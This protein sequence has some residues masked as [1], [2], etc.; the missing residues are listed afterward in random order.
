MNSNNKRNSVKKDYDLIAGQ[1]CEEFGEYI[2]DLDIYEEFEKYL[3]LGDT[4]LDLGAGAGRTYC[5]FNKK[6]YN[7]IALDFSSKMRECAFKKYGVFPYILD[8]MVNIKKHFS[9]NTIDAV[10]V[11][12]SLFHLPKDD[13]E[14]LMLDL[15]DILKNNGLILLSF[16]LGDGE[17]F[18][19]EPYLKSNG[20][21]VLYMNYMDKT[22]IFDLLK[23]NKFDILYTKEKYETGENVIGEDGNDAI[24]I[25]ARNK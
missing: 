18:V 4:I 8:D 20:Q 5:Y 3:V 15:H 23:K 17:A 12:Y 7:Y 24:Y 10:F 19:D 22:Q 6:G 16:Q 21:K 13:L 14:N 2:E 1:Y 11:L 9:N 25:I